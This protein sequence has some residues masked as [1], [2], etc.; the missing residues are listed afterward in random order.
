VLTYVHDT[1]PVDVAEIYE[2]ESLSGMEHESSEG[3]VTHQ[4]PWFGVRSPLS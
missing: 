2:I 4:D 3:S 1:D